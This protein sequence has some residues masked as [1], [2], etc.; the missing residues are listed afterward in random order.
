MTDTSYQADSIQV[1][2]DLPTARKLINF[3]ELKH[4]WIK[5]GDINKLAEK[6]NIAPKVL[7]RFINEEKILSL[8]P[9]LEKSKAPLLSSLKF[10]RELLL[11]AQCYNIYNLQARQLRKVVEQ[12][13]K[14]LERDPKILIT[15]LQHDLI[16]GSLLGD[17]SVRQRDKHCNFRV[18]HTVKQKNY[19]LW[20]YDILEEYTLSQPKWNART[21]NDNRPLRTLELATTTHY[22]FNFYRNLFYKNGIKRVTRKILD[23]LNAQ[24]LAIWVC[25]DGSY[26]TTQDYIILCTNSYTLAE[27]KIMKQYFKN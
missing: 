6:L 7:S 10:G 2:R 13:R 21:I 26:S 25:D 8:F 27:H 18:G 16:V 20:K 23:L 3:D 17:A 11:F 12:W 22:S 9:N 19:L 15:N 4:L 14:Q 5:R 1:I 24:S